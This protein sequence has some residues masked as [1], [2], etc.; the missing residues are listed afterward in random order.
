MRAISGLVGYSRASRVMC[1]R[2]D[3]KGVFSLASSSLIL[4]RSNY[5]QIQFNKGGKTAH[6]NSIAFSHILANLEGLS[7]IQLLWDKPLVLA[8]C[9]G[10]SK[11]QQNHPCRHSWTYGKSI[12]F[13]TTTG[14]L[15][16][17][18]AYVV[19]MA[20]VP[21]STWSR[22]RSTTMTMDFNSTACVS[23]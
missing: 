9:N 11:Q 1:G 12:V 10:L 17:I 13:Y 7:L 2:R 16:F 20:K 21:Y 5:H 3:R 22:W 8:P 14:T 23:I 19:T 15:E 18:S 4:L 6:T